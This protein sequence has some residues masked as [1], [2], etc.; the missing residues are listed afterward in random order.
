MSGSELLHPRLCDAD[1]VCSVPPRERGELCKAASDGPIV[2]CCS[3]ARHYIIFGGCTI[4]TKRELELPVP[5]ERSS[6]PL[7]SIPK[8]AVCRWL[9]MLA[10]PV[11]KTTFFTVGL[12]AQLDMRG[13]ARRA[14]QV[15]P[16]PPP[17]APPVE[18]VAALQRL[19]QLPAAVVAGAAYPADI[20]VVFCVWRTSPGVVA[21]ASGGRARADLLSEDEGRTRGGRRVQ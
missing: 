5:M 7:G 17:D 1:F 16:Q 8:L 2:C 4:V 12:C 3:G 11:S 19:R 9:G 10:S 20:V 18:A 13:V 14:G 21:L 6:L 15:D